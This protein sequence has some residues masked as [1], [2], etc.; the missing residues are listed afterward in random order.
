MFETTLAILGIIRAYPSQGIPSVFC[1]CPSCPLLVGVPFVDF[2]LVLPLSVSLFFISSLFSP[3]WCSCCLLPP[4][5]PLVSDFS[6]YFL[7]VLALSVSRLCISY[8]SSA[9]RFPLFDFSSL[10]STFRILDTCFQCST[11]FCCPPEPTHSVSLPVVEI[12]REGEKLLVTLS[13]AARS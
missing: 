4:C 9:C 13:I 8:L 7:L 1:L 12:K 2:L 11:S 3:D 10:V 5:P 6:V